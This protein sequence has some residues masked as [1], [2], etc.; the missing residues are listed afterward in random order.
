MKKYFIADAHIDLSDN[1]IFGKKVWARN[2]FYYSQP[3][4]KTFPIADQFNMKLWQKAKS[5]N[6]IGGVLCP[7]KFTK[8]GNLAVPKDPLHELLRHL[9][10]YR[11]IE[12]ESGGK[13]TFIKNKSDITKSFKNGKLNIFLHIE[14]LLFIQE[15]IDIEMVQLLW[16]LGIRSI[17]IMHSEK[18]PLGGIEEQY[19]KDPGLT[20]LGVNLVRKISQ[21]GIILD[22]AHA[23]DQT[24][25]DI[26]KLSDN[27][28]MVSHTHIRQ[29]VGDPGTHLNILKEVITKGG[30][31][32]FHFIKKRY[33][34]K[35]ASPIDTLVDEMKKF[36]NLFGTKNFGLGSDFDGMRKI[37][38]IPG[39]ENITK[40]SVLAKKLK[41]A[42]FSN[43]ET[44]RIMGKNLAKFL[45]SSL[46]GNNANI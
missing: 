20:K 30:Y 27:K 17:G 11:F 8:K 1:I 10:V 19:R 5:P 37:N 22:L 41:K 14:G 39:L 34:Y 28:V 6:L 40:Y 12:S 18:S 23:S 43:E 44:G 16:D 13:V 26:L 33:L 21:L 46:P 2:E 42:G 4:P 3:L 45:I 9:M 38:Q 29:G 15:K 36:A 32:G 31:V 25:K 7:I 35:D 24:Q